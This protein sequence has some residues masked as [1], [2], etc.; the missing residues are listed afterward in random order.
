MGYE[1]RK[2]LY[3]QLEEHR[4]NPLI[5][6]VTSIRPNLSSQM[7][8]DVI[9]YIIKQ[10]ERIGSSCREIDFLIV[11]NGG[12]PLTAHRINSILRERF[13]RINVLVPYVA[14]SAATIFALGADS[15]VMG[16]YSNLGPVDPQVRIDKTSENGIKSGL[17]FSSEDIHFY[18]EYLTK[19]IKISKKH[20]LSSLTKTLIDE[21]GPLEIG[22]TKRAKEL[23]LFLSRKLLSEHLNDSKTIKKISN[24]FNTS[25]HH[26]YAFS[27]SEVKKLGLNVSIPDAKTE[28]LMWKIW[29]DYSNEMKCNNPFD[30]TNEILNN[31]NNLN[32]TSVQIANIPANLPAQFAQGFWNSIIS[33][34]QITTQSSTNL[35]EKLAFLE[36]AGDGYSVTTKICV[37]AFRN[38]QFELVTNATGYSEGW[39][40]E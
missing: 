4:G 19:E 34:I 28:E 20:S 21:I 23:S 18:N 31:I 17:Q 12:D 37:I 3:R 38:A 6:Y 29:E 33:K 22:K 11:S 13:D 36:S 2:K 8:A 26:G 32:L 15:I 27:R 7:A 10:V 35:V 40:E 24:K 5:S 1:D 16:L 30:I 25:F 39:C 9:P 14:Y